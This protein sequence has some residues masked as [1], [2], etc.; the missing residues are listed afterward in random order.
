M[1]QHLED[2]PV[3][4]LHVGHPQ[5]HRREIF[6]AHFLRRDRHLD[7][8]VE[9]AFGF[10]G[11]RGEV[12]QRR[13]VAV[14]A[15]VCS[16]AERRQR[17]ER[18]H[19]GRYVRCKAL[20]EK[21]PQRLV[22]PGLD[23][24]RRPVVQD[25]EPEDVILRLAQRHRLAE[26]IARPDIEGDLG[27]VIERHGRAE[28]RHVGI[29]R[30]GL[31]DRALAGF[32]ADHDRRRAAVIGDGDML[33][34]GHQR[35]VG[36]QHHADIGRVKDRRIEVGIVADLR[37]QPHRHIRLRDQDFVGDRLRGFAFLGIVA[38]RPRCR[39]AQRRPVPPAHR[40]QPVQ[41]FAGAGAGGIVRRAADHALCARRR[42][43]ENHVADGDAHGAIAGLRIGI[44]AEGQVLDGEIGAGF[45]GAVD[46]ACQR[47]VM[48]F[49]QFG[50]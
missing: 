2:R 34:I 32:A 7:I 29:G 18:H 33:V 25:A 24:A 30:L 14:G 31:A 46:P 3:Q 4:V 38:Q 11:G 49:V 19:P 6:V 26:R 27:L 28:G 12:G 15:F 45:V 36:P 47:G 23:V 17:F 50:H 35:V 1:G 44:D 37:R 16:R 22:F 48:G 43:V 41:G 8:H 39:G 20:G 21:R 5:G 40:H 13:R 10:I 9:P 42:H